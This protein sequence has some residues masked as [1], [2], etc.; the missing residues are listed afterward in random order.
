MQT[1]L[2]KIS[3]IIATHNRA[4]LLV[5][6]VESILNQTLQDFELI[7]INDG[8]TDNT[9]EVLF[10]LAKRDKRIKA[11]S[12]EKN[13][14]NGKT[15][16]KALEI[17]AGEYIAMLGDDDVSLPER[18][19]IQ[20]KYLDENP[21]VSLMFSTFYKADN[22]LSILDVE[23]KNV[24]DGGFPED[25]ADIFT[26]LYLD[27]CDIVDSSCMFRRGILKDVGGYGTTSTGTDR[28]F[29]LKVAAKGFKIR[30]IL[31]P[32]VVVRSSNDYKN[33]LQAKRRVVLENRVKVV[34]GTRAW[35][36]ENN[37]HKFDGLHS[38][39]LSNALARYARSVGGLRGLWISIRAF[40]TLPKNSIARRNLK[41][42]L[43]KMIK[44]FTPNSHNLFTNL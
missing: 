12:N 31:Q 8:S 7:L 38:K 28:A 36:G 35:L 34:K 44:K 11:Y 19:E 37:I 20:A 13:I 30:P 27:R 43:S 18:L 22:N 29:F 21:T 40:L 42:Y 41:A 10:E 17:A 5:S 6:S 25:P 2:P 14:G 9:Q 15:R 4:H 26:Q 32:L 1:K 3:V 16:N 39:A 33:H 24:I 23:P